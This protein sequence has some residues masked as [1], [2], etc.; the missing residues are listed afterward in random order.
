MW[1]AA[2]AFAFVVRAGEVVADAV[3]D[4]V[5]VVADRPEVIQCAYFGVRWFG[6]AAFV[7]FQRCG[8]G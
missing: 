1:G 4:R 7:L 6:T 5:F 8:I 3:A 2:V